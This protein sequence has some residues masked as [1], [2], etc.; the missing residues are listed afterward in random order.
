MESIAFPSNKAAATLLLTH[1]SLCIFWALLAGQP[2]D[3][4]LDLPFV[5]IMGINQYCINPIITITAIVAFSLQART[6]NQTRGRSSLNQMSLALQI[7]VF[8]ALAVSWPFRFRVPRN[9]YL[10]VDVWWLEVW[11]PLVGWTCVN[12]AVIAFG[13]IIVLYAVFRVGSGAEMGEERQAL[14]SP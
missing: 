10:R 7:F 2:R 11:Y 8:L 14:L 4:W 5:T 3:D 6:A 13:Q 12:S 9:L 1:A